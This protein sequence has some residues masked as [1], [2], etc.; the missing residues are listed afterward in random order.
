MLPKYIMKKKTGYFILL[1][2][3]V[4]HLLMLHYFGIASYTN[5]LLLYALFYLFVKGI[6]ILIKNKHYKELFIR[7]SQVL[8]MLMLVFEFFLAF[9]FKINNNYF[10][11]ERG[12][13]LSEYKHTEQINLLH[14][15]GRKKAKI[16]WESGYT[17][18]SERQHYSQ[19]FNYSIHMNQLGLRGILPPAEKD[20]DEYRITV[21]GDSF[22]E[23][24][25]VQNDS[26]TFPEIL[27]RHL[28][29]SKKKI[30]VINAGICG[31]NP[32]YEIRLYNKLLHDYNNDLIILQMNL[33]DLQDIEY[34]YNQGKMPLSEYFY[35]SSHIFRIIY[36]DIL[37]NNFI[38]ENC[39]RH[40]EVR[41][42]KILQLLTQQLK[43]FRKSLSE[44]NCSLFLVYQPII[45]EIYIK[46]KNNTITNDLAL[47]LEM[48]GIPLIN[49]K[50]EYQ[51]IFKGNFR[52]IE[53]FYWKKDKHHNTKG[54][55]LMA[56]TVATKLKE[57]NLLQT[58]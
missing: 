34:T 28:Y 42:R 15:L 3:V 32:Y 25:G 57:M 17:P 31:S 55:E 10:E 37:G 45:E 58:N 22:I 36:S 33:S 19:D 38:A 41:R 52:E 46:D 47:A 5:T 43:N 30:S 16:A 2:L 27:H 6:A 7:N 4:V 35:A 18:F 48:S 12:I 11:N 20:T 44:E 51:D 29:N 14:F 8:L 26:L 39:N 50:T 49:L 53:Q 40:T 54:Y 13:Y 24:F 23:G 9:I 21:L 56:V 1:V